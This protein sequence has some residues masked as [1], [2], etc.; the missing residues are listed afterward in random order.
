MLAYLPTAPQTEGNLAAA[1]VVL[2]AL[3]VG[4][5]LGDFALQSDFLARAKNRRSN[6]DGFFPN[7]SPRGVWISALLA[8]SLIHAGAVWLC[9]GS[10]VLGLVELALHANIDF[11]KGEGRVSFGVDQALHLLCKVIYVVLLYIGF[12]WLTWSP[13]S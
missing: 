12:D 5:A 10:V 11:V 4:H 7:G 1:L 9:T 8:H 13:V 2:F 3:L 6:L